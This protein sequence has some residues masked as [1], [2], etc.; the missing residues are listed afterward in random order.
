MQSVY[1]VDAE[2]R[3]RVP[4]EAFEA[5]GGQAGVPA[6][7]TPMDGSPPPES[8]VRRKKSSRAAGVVRDAKPAQKKPAKAGTK[9]TKKKSEAKR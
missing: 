4:R 3:V 6:G 9:N 2:G 5:L 1:H 7:F 8:T